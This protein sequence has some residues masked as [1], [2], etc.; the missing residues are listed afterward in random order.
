M[1]KIL[2]IDNTAHHVYGQ[3]HLMQAL[4]ALGY[5]VIAAIPKDGVFSAKLEQNGVIVEDFNVDSK[6][7]NPFKDLSLLLKYIKL[8]KLYRPVLVCSFTIKPNLYGSLAAKLTNIS[9]IA[10][11]TG[12]GYVFMRNN[13]ISLVAIF[14]YKI[15]F[16]FSNFIFCQNKDDL[17]I[18]VAKGIIKRESQL[19]LLPGSGVDLIKFSYV[20]IKPTEQITFMY[21][22]RLLW[23]KGI[24]ELIKAFRIVRGNFP[25]IKLILIGNYFPSNPAAISPEIIQGWQKEGL[26]EYKGMVDNVFDEMKDIDCVIL[27]SYREG[28]PR[29]LLEAS[30]MGKPIITV[31]SVGCKDVVEDGVTG[32]MAKTANV[33]TLVVA[34]A[35][36]I[37]LPFDKKIE[38]GKHGRIKMEKE[39]DQ[40]IV[41]DKYMQV[42]NNLLGRSV[43]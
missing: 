23:D 14:L 36:F 29:S 37:K 22:G 8:L 16:R 39:F 30:S 43:D 4:L 26:I 17:G 11:V 6:S 3:F 10:N 9:I 35:K 32:F 20:G 25:N 5:Q 40:Q 41:I 2:F 34:M 38:M 24:G 12:L 18:L 15:C 1:K 28:M 13:L 7:V 27:P 19:G 42:V 33:E 21:S 31:D